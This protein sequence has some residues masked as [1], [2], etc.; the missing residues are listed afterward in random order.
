M[1][2][3]TGISIWIIR[4]SGTLQLVL[5]VLFWTGH[6]YQYLPLHIVNGVVIVLTLW[7]AAVL[8]LVARTRRGLA[9]F[10]LLWGLALPAFGMAQA[11]LLVGS[12]HWI[13]RVTH[14]VMGLAAMGIAGTLGQAVLAALPGAVHG[15]DRAVSA[16]ATGRAR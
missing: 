4:V 8:A 9:V 16:V 6:A 5:G 11:T 10:A 3:I 15:S 12:M 14:L 13:I 7:T 1:R 2:T